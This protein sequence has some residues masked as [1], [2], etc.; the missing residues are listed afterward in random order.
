[1]NQTKN[2]IDF[3][4][5][6][7]K[8]DRLLPSHISMYVSLFQLWSVNSFRNPFRINREDVMKVSKIKSLATYHKCI[9]ELHQSGF[10]VY[11]PSYNA[12]RGSLI[13]MTD[14]DSEVLFENIVVR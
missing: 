9:R 8:D 14:F 11:S 2:I 6:I 7:I 5:R 10:I 4:E 13:E 1:M 3:F 12:Y